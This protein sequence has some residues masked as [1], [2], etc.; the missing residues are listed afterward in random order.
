MYKSKFFVVLI[1]AVYVLFVVFEFSGNSK[2]ALYFESLIVPLVVVRYLIFVKPKNKLFLL[3]LVFFGLSDLLGVIDKFVYLDENSI[4]YEYVYYIGNCLYIL[5]YTILFVRICKSINFRYILKN[6]KIHLFILAILNSYLIYVLHTIEKPEV[7]T[8]IDYYL[9]N[10]YNIVILMVLAISL[11]N[12][13]YRDNEK[14]LFLFFGVLCLVFSEIIDVANIFIS[15]SS[16]LNFLSTTLVLGAFY[17]FYE[18]S[19][20][21]NISHRDDL[22]YPDLSLK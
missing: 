21:S 7:G 4:Y 2:L 10:A 20:L 18:Q 9:E 6:L 14:S 13:F 19:K 16:L 8:S 11:L 15:E 17:F 3:F 12:Y 22:N 1:V 5:A